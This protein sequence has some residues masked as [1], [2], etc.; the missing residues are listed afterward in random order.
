MPKEGDKLHQLI[1]AVFRDYF[2]YAPVKRAGRLLT[3][4]AK[5]PDEV[6]WSGKLAENSWKEPFLPHREKLFESRRGLLETKGEQPPVACL[7]MNILDLKAL[8]LF[9]LVFGND[10][11]YQNR[12][13]KILVI[14]YGADWPNSYKKS[15]VFSHNF[16][17]DALEHV[18][19]DIFIAGRKSGE[20]VFYSGSAAGRKLLESCRIKNFENIKFAGAVAESGPDK[21]MLEI[22]GKLERSADHYL[23]NNLDQICLACGK[24]TI[25]CPTCF[26]FDLEDKVN[27]DD[28]RRDRKW[29]SCFYND[30]SLVAGGHKELDTVKKK[31]FFWYYHKF[32]RIPKEYSYVGCVSCG[33]CTRTCPVNIDIAKNIAKILKMK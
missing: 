5:T 16:K 29:G 10:V 25:A 6:D 11:Y 14:G 12:R 18:S 13:Q 17:E 32:A 1:A 23:W 4:E 33:R 24:C 7:G 8:T 31:I 19:F 28:P 21:R 27:P 2:V 22:K 30:F 20:P 26:C 9:D 15:K 3:Q